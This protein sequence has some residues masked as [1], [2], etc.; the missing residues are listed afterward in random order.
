[1]QEL[2]RYSVAVVT[3][4]SSGIGFVLLFARSGFYTYV[5]IRTM[6][7]INRSFDCLEYITSVRL[8]YL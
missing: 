1:M 7:N 2:E 5:T 6:R 8:V 4:S 3:D